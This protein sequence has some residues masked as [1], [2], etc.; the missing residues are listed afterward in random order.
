LIVSL[1]S[2]LLVIG[3]S[4]IIHEL[5]HFLFSI[6]FGVKVYEFAFGMGPAFFQKRRGETLYSIRA[7]PIGGFVRLAGMEEEQEGE[8]APAE[9]TYPCKS[10]L[11]RFA[12]LAGGPF[13]NILLAIILTT[14]LL[15]FHGVLDVRSA[16]VGSTM[17]GYPAERIGL[18]E[19]DRILSIN[20]KT[21]TS[22]DSMSSALRSEAPKGPVSL[23][24][25]RK[26]QTLTFSVRVE[27]DPKFGVPL[28]G[29][30]PRNVRYPLP[31]AIFRSVGTAWEMTVSI[32]RGLWTWA[33]GKQSVEFAG[34]VGIAS[35][36]GDA[37]RQGWW[38]FISFLAVINLNL[39][40]LNLFP[41]PALDGGRL[42]F[43]IGEMLTGRRLPAKWEN[44][45]HV[46]GFAL[47]LA[48][49]VYVTWKDILR[50]ARP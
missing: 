38:S 42:F 41:F 6:R 34:P 47:L 36:A 49:I 12:I 20:G 30:R 10:P 35:M 48:L 15:A 19:G 39:G 18:L 14:A 2:F 7:F 50:L 22:W 23:L 32:L 44:L 21:V 46:A 40:I 24:V 37:A 5:G 26:G 4:V 27:K 28:L 31:E 25:E 9:R 8:S 3:I 45:I 43:L 33:F 16:T 17:S 11:Q 13:F 29:I 1:L